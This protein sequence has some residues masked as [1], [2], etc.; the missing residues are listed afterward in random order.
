MLYAVRK[1]YRA[2]TGAFF[3]FWQTEPAAGVELYYFDGEQCA[4]SYVKD[5]SYFK[6]ISDVK[7]MSYVK[8]I[9]YVKD[10][11]L[12][13]GHFLDA[14]LS[15]GVLARLR[16]VHKCYVNKSSLSLSFSLFLSLSPLSLSL[17][18]ALSL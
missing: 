7:D 3:F 6:D 9:S 1:H 8:D 17:A 18:R 12:C 16:C 5:I 4:G 11:F 2:L 10:N 13:Q 14:S 15:G